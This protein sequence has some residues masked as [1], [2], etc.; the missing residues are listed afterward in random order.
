MGEGEFFWVGEGRGAGG[1]CGR[2]E[3]GGGGEQ[4]RTNERPGTDHVTSGLMKG[5]EKKLHSMVQTDRRT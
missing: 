3:G 2:E 5:L 1:E 4:G